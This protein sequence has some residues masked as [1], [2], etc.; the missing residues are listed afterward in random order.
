[1]GIPIPASRRP[2]VI[3]FAFIATVIPLIHAQET[4]LEAL[5]L[6]PS[7]DENILVERSADG[8]AKAVAAML[9]RGADPN[10]VDRAGRTALH[11]AA[12]RDHLDVMR[13][14]IDHGADVNVKDAAGASVLHEAASSHES[15]A[16]EI[17][18]QAGAR[19]DGAALAQACWLGR[20]KT[21]KLLLDAGA[22]PDDGMVRAAQGG[23]AEILKLLLAR[24]ANANTKS[25][26]G[27]RPLH[28]A[29][30]QGGFETVRLLLEADADAN[31]GNNNAETPLHMAIAGDGD[32]ET[33]KLL[34]QSGARLDLPNIE[35]VTPVR[36][37]AIRAEDDIYEWL[38]A[39]NGGSE[40]RF[41][42]SDAPF[43]PQRDKSTHELLT[44]FSAATRGKE[45]LAVQGELVLR[46]KQIMPSVL[47]HVE[48]GTPIEA[49]YQL[50]E[51]MGPEAEEA[52]PL[53]TQQLSK[54]DHVFV[55]A[56]TI[57]RM[58]PGARHALPEEAKQKMAA[59]L[60]EM[61][62][63]TPQ[64]VLAGI[65]TDLLVSMGKSAAP[66]IIRLLRHKTP[67]YRRGTARAIASV[68]F[69]DER[70]EAELVKMAQSDEINSVRASAA[71]A[72]RACT[73]PSKTTR[74]AL[75]SIICSPPHS[76]P[77]DTDARSRAELHDWRITADSAATSLARFG[78]S[79]IGDLVPLL[80]PMESRTRHPAITA[81]RTMGAP[82]VPRLIELLA[83]QDRAVAVS[84]SVALNRIG[85]PAVPALAQAVNSGN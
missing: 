30:L 45:R 24:G 69:S 33:V 11:R 21:M 34:V 19:P 38:V 68:P 15:Q 23:H 1:M 51:A 5:R 54:K 28:T 58:K 16:V 26:G 76:D 22:T 3:F 17:L 79:V 27:D 41:S 78:P 44:T 63:D 8:N 64:P 36:Y 73:E 71:A 50:F 52:L 56:I 7:Q 70:I 31:A 57:E 40:P 47:Q 83:H 46:G 43:P 61:I 67:E 13:L 42:R 85:K 25:R 60:Y 14:L 62:A 74:D 37:A 4:R 12:Q 80:S 77:Q 29:A 59:A 84:A 49:F 72:L 35:G 18:L 75:L 66:N 53:I 9:D 39:A 55:A 32:L 65:G 20:S 6:T 10:S 81:L 48:S 82:A 2:A